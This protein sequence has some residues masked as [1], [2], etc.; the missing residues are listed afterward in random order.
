MN[1]G[2][3]GGS[4]DPF[5]KGHESLVNG[6][7]RSGIVDVVILIPSARNPFKKGRS[8]TAAPYRYYMVKNA[9]DADL[10]KDKVFVS[11][12]EFTYSGTSFT[13]TTIKEISKPSYIR[14]FLKANG[15]KSSDAETPHSFFW[16]TGSD[17]LPT[18]EKWREADKILEMAGLLVASR[19]GDGVDVDEQITRLRGVFGNRSDIRVFDIKGVEAASS[20]IRTEHDYVKVSDT[21]IDFIRTHDLY[22]DDNVLDLVS[23]E[24][25][26]QFYENAIKLYR[27]LGEKRLL[28]TLNVGL[29]S[30][31]YAS[32]YDRTLCDRA[33]I[34]GELHD[35]AKE[36]DEALQR[37]MATEHSGDVFTEKKL[38]H[39]PAGAVFANQEFGVTDPGI[40]DAITYHTTG[41]G[42][43]SLLD[44]IVYL[45]D[46]LEPSRTYADLTRERELAVTDIDAALRLCVGSTTKK[47]LSR[48]QDVHPL[49]L[50]F[51]NDIGICE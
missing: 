13:L 23:D 44:K 17:V 16:I 21:V 18:F 29:L 36:L 9:V 41:R 1:I 31:R 32:V 7:L 40:L 26:E 3:L 24:T 43:M 49:T 39:S 30:L 25:C 12:I 5:H 27:Y 4:F 35:C 48:G 38:L 8:V 42:G 45:A 19:P 11:D 6:A 47:L 50:D 37:E 28:H 22:R 14:T 51:M 34:A 20:D 46:K 33:L 10:K 15:I 2:L